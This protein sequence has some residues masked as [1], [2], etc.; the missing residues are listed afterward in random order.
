MTD[1]QAG[2]IAAGYE[3]EYT[4]LRDEIL[5]RIELRQQ[6][7]SLT[8]TIA[9]VFLG[10]GVANGPVA[11][12]YPPLAIFLAIA[13]VQN[14]GRLQEAAGYIRNHLEKVIPGLGW[15]QHLERKRLSDARRGKLRT[16][17]LSHGG[18]F[19][20]TQLIAIA[21]GLLKFSFSAGEWI[22][23]GGSVVSVVLV[24][25][26]LLQG[27]RTIDRPSAPSSQPTL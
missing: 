18:T 21:I 13:W 6:I 11:F 10:I 1:A 24:I 5:R 23:L 8:L 9:G 3:L 17:L 27:Q 26:A 15:E 20:F 25:R 7:L 12:V 19:L 4:V 14:D 22:L 16:T 2:Q